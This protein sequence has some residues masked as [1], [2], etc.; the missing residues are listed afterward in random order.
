MWS[1]ENKKFMRRAMELALM[2]QGHVNPN[3]MVGAVI[4]RDGQVLSEGWHRVYGSLHAET[5]ALSSCPVDP[6][7]A[8]M[9]VTLEPCCHYGKQPPCTSAILKAGISRVVVGMTD[10]N[11]LVAG[12]GVEIL[13]NNG[14]EVITGLFEDEIRHL[15]RVFVKYIVT[16][17]PWVVLKSAMT[18]DGRIAAA[19]GDSKWVTGEEARHMVHELRGRYMGIVAGIGTVRADDPML[20]CR[21][22]GM[23]QPLRIVVDS[24]ASISVDFRLVRTAGEFRT[25]VAHTSSASVQGLETLRSLG[26]ELLECAS[27]ADGRVSLPDLLS[28]LGAMSVDSLLVEGGSELDWSLVSQGLVDEYY[29]FVAPKIIGGRDARGPVGGQGFAWMAEA[30]PVDVEQVSQVG[31]DWLFHGFARR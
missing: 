26:V 16:K 8:T 29:M 19:S 24:H 10:P 18:L 4:V 31:S 30:L 15:N 13:R 23:R 25:L 11:P 6:A 1:E 17:R 12:H 28:R 20:N 7:G 3:P 2:G 22:D 21:L 14:V 27:D 5:D 9:Y